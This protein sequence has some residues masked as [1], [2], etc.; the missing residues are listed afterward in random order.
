MGPGEAWMIPLGTGMCASL[1]ATRAAVQ[2][3]APPNPRQ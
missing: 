3:F 2:A 1:T